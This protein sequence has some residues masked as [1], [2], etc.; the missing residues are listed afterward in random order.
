MS[1]I[2]R[3]IWAS[4]VTPAVGGDWVRYTDHQAEVEQMTR[5]RSEN[6]AEIERLTRA[7]DGLRDSLREAL[8]ERNDVRHEAVELREKLGETRAEVERLKALIVSQ[9]EVVQWAADGWPVALEDH[10]QQAIEAIVQEA[11]EREQREAAAKEGR[12]E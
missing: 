7:R 5:Q 4:V 6:F 3:F 8:E 9:H 10:E 11:Q 12:D 2:E 1:D